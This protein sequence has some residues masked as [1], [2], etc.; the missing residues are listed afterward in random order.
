MGGTCTG[1]HGIGQ[2]KIAYME[3]EHG[4][5]TLGLMRSVKATFFPQNLINPGKLFAV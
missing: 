4:L 5:P 2:K 1:E 3:D